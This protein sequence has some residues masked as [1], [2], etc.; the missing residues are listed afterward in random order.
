M[1]DA[2]VAAGSEQV[3]STLWPILADTGAKFAI[4]YLS[5]SGFGYQLASELTRLQRQS[6]GKFD[7]FQLF[8]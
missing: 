1:A 7:G 8:G 6:P 2:F 3:V 5:S 4:D